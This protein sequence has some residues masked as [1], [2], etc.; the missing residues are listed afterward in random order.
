MSR[1]QVSKELK[2]KRNKVVEV[3]K[4]AQ[5]ELFDKKIA[6]LPK[7]IQKRKEQFIDELKQ[8]NL[9]KEDEEGLIVIDDKGF[10]R[11]ELIEHAFEPLI[12]GYG[13]KP[14]Y[15]V[16]NLSL[17]FDYFR[18]LV[19]EL[20]K[21]GIY[22]PTKEDFCSLMGVSTEKFSDLKNSNSPEMRE[23]CMQV[24]NYISRI[25]SQG[26]FTE[27]IQQQYATFYQKARMNWRDN[28]PVQFNNLT[29]NNTITNDEKLKELREKLLN[30][31]FEN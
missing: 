27:K 19:I 9:A 7:Y 12:R 22:V 24:E 13:Y 29:V 25:I 4:E 14:I 5:K 16:E 8:Y 2:T 23:L 1:P 26:A 6:D 17:V 31:N 10:Q 11:M 28:D 21:G 18:E 30:N 15:S 20:N 3:T